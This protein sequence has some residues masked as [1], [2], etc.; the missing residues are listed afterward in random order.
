MPQGSVHGIKVC[1]V[2]CISA[3]KINM[4][5]L[6][7]F[8]N[9]PLGAEYHFKSKHSLSVCNLSDINVDILTSNR[10]SLKI[11]THMHSRSVC[12]TYTP[13]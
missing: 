11:E 2:V 3:Y 1:V 9:R 12:I 7:S 13:H 6:E 10:V 8:F 4:S 5:R